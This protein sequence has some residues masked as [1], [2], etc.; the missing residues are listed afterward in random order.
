MTKAHLDTH[1]NVHF[2]PGLHAYL[3]WPDVAALHAPRPLMVQQCSQDRL[4]P[5]DAMKE[6]VEKIEAIYKK[7]GAK[8]EFVGRFYD[9]PHRFTKKMQEEAFAWLD[10]HLLG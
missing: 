9:E 3:D 10:R 6:S 2:V 1:S 5:L 4:F 7:A 8:G